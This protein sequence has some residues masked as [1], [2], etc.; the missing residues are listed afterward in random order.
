MDSI[1][2][3]V[4]FLSIAVFLLVSYV[5]HVNKQ[6]E[7][8]KQRFFRK[9]RD[10]EARLR[11][12]RLSNI[13]NM[14]GIE[15]EKYVAWLLEQKGYQQV[16]VTKGSGDFG[17][18]I[19]ASYA[20]EKYAIQVKRY[21]SNISRR[22]VSDAVAGKDHYYC[23]SA[24][25]VTNSYFTKQAKV[26]AESVNCELVDR[27]ILIDWIQDFCINKKDHIQPL[28]VVNK[29]PGRVMDRITKYAMEQEQ[30][31]VFYCSQSTTIE[32]EI[33]AYKELRKLKITAKNDVPELFFKKIYAKSQRS[34]HASI[35]DQLNE[36]KED[37]EA[38]KNNLKSNLINSANQ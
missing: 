7:L 16:E 3:G 36:I 27:D 37:I 19:V 26:F 25:V 1:I 11:A 13:D 17:V 6:G 23:S 8:K 22:A 32:F 24:M 20:G 14:E 9:Q 28:Q 34:N 10:E 15:F 21:S 18:D 33:E 31:L 30:D 4:I 38:Y 5:K 29:I 2:G 12:I 35:W